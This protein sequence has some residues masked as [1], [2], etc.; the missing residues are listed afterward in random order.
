VEVRPISG[1]APSRGDDHASLLTIIPARNGR[2][3]AVLGYLLQPA[4]G[5]PADPPQWAPE[6]PT[7]L[8]VDRDQR[9]VLLDGQEIE[10][11][12]QEFEL[13]DFLAAHPYRT[14][15]REQI[16]AGAWAGRQQATG[17]TVDVHVHRLRRKL[18]P[19]YARYVVTVQ[20]VGYTFHPPRL[21]AAP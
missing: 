16:I 12:F 10:L 9:R 11:V 6:P 4:P 17:R 13:L 15:T 20:R 19:D 7:G 2:F 14:F 18:G 21:A 3:P 1:A 5:G 8:V